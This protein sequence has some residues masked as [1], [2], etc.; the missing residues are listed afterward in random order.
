V[1]ALHPKVEAD[2]LFS[3][4]RPRHERSG[5]AVIIDHNLGIIATI[6]TSADASRFTQYVH[7]CSCRVQLQDPLSY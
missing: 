7:V 2:V 5:A 3:T 1:A 4:R 6:T